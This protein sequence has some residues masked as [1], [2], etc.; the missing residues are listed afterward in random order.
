MCVAGCGPAISGRRSVESPLFV[1]RTVALGV[2][3]GEGSVFP[4][5]RW[6]AVFQDLAGQYSAKQ[7]LIMVREDSG[8]CGSE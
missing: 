4:G 6:E 7:Y 8:P 3:S 1:A 5:T 2:L